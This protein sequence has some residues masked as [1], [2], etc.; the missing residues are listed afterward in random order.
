MTFEQW[1][2]IGKNLGY[3][4][5]PFCNTHDGPPLH[6]TEEKA[7]FDHGDDPCCACV[8]LGVPNDWAI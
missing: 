3:C 5:S 6:E 8:R 7:I 2:Q 1:L 4:T